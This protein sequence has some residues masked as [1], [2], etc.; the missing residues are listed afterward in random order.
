MPSKAPENLPIL[1]LV[2]QS[3]HVD[4]EQLERYKGGVEG[5]SSDVRS[6]LIAIR[7]VF[8]WSFRATDITSSVVSLAVFS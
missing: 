4:R 1:P 8:I 3:I 6:H 2:K 5:A 7:N